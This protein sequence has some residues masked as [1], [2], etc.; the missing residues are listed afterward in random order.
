MLF[1]LVYKSELRLITLRLVQYQ[2]KRPPPRNST[3]SLFHNAKH[4]LFID[5][6][7][8]GELA[9][10]ACVLTQTQV[11]QIAVHVVT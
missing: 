2:C 6:A 5:S 11:R 4:P 10:L 7:T 9:A 1:R 3:S 8:E